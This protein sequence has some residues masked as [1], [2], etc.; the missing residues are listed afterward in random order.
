MRVH[1]ELQKVLVEGVARQMEA[2]REGFESV[3]PLHHLQT[4]Y[5][6]ELDELFCGEGGGEEQASR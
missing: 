6:E 2:L 3:V 5:P 1:C 4:F